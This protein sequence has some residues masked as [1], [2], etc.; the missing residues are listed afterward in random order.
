MGSV[1]EVHSACAPILESPAALESTAMLCP[2]PGV[3]LGAT[4][5]KDGVEPEPVESRSIHVLLVDDDTLARQVV[6]KA[7]E[8]FGYQG[9]MHI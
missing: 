9:M 4:E 1:V 2:Q 3:Q 8:K 6:R 5:G 7:L